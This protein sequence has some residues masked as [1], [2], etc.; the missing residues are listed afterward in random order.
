[1]FEAI[2]GSAPRMVKEGRDIGKVVEMRI[3]AP[4]KASAEDSPFV[5]LAQDL[6]DEITDAGYLHIAVP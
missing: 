4:S 6:C 5:F 2:H 1:M 3:S